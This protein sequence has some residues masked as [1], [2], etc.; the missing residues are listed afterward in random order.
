[1]VTTHVDSNSP[2]SKHTQNK[3]TIPPNDTTTATFNF[4][5][6]TSSSSHFSSSPPQQPKSSTSSSLDELNHGDLLAKQSDVTVGGDAVPPS[7]EYFGFALYVGSAGAFLLYSLWAYLPRAVLHWLNI[8]YYP[9]RWWAL[10]IP[11]YITVTMGYIYVALAAYNTEVLTRGADDLNT[12]T[13]SMAKIVPSR[14]GHRRG[15]GTGGWSESLYATRRNSRI[16]EV[17]TTPNTAEDVKPVQ[18]SSSLDTSVPAP[19]LRLNRPP[20]R[21]RSSAPATPTTLSA[22]A[23]PFSS[24]FSSTVNLNSLSSSSAKP[25]L[26]STQSNLT[27]NYYLFHPSD[28]V[29]DL[30]LSEVCAVLYNNDNND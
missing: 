13:D 8:Y 7:T 1:M 4:A 23:S 20:A 12:V 16:E 6:S 22:S 27:L 25:P 29:W 10:V 9:S 5:S 30:P 3:E 28:G 26:P 15:T 21:P 14:L 17:V 18:N 2:F 19:T 11:A 24:P